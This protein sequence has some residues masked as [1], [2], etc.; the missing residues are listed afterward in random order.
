MGGPPNPRAMC[1]GEAA[2]PAHDAAMGTVGGSPRS[3]RKVE[4]ASRAILW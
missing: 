1:F 4:F 2:S 3:E